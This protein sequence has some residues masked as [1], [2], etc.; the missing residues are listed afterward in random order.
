MAN[1]KE[2]EVCMQQMREKHKHDKFYK[3]GF[4]IVLVLLAIMS[5]LYF[6]TGDIFR[7]TENKNAD[8]VIE[9]GG[10]GNDNNVTVTQ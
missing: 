2:C 4:W 7:Y 3:I 1:R 5:T 8:I 10:D 9:N 6:A